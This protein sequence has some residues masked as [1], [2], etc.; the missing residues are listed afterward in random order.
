[1]LAC[2]GVLLY[3]E[4]ALSTP[5]CEGLFGLIFWFSTGDGTSNG[6]AGNVLG[7]AVEAPF[8]GRNVRGPALRVAW[9]VR[10]GS[11]SSRMSERGR[12]VADVHGA[13]IGGSR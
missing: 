4:D 8:D 10:L 12:I 3:D 7:E 2:S 6:L 9:L 13:G 5:L 1:M 11:L